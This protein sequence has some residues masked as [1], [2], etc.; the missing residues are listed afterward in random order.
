VK[1]LSIILLVLLT[2]LLLSAC[3]N[4]G[5]VDYVNYGND[6][7]Y[8]EEINDDIDVTYGPWT[9]AAQANELDPSLIGE[10]VHYGT[11]ATGEFFP[12]T[13]EWG[14]NNEQWI[15]NDDGSGRHLIWDSEEIFY[16]ATAPWQLDFPPYGAD[17]F[18]SYGML[19][20]KGEDGEFLTRHG[21]PIGYDYFID[22]DGLLTLNFWLAT[23]E[24][25]VFRR[26]Q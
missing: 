22:Y 19:V 4:V 18:S 13:E 12:A 7:E 14:D 25:P 11:Y 26:A 8:T 20:L 15:F 6:Y 9:W 24:T 1:K 3:S 16:W 17:N 21:Y 2:V 5:D 10:W 23:G